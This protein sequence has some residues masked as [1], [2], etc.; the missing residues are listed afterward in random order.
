MALFGRMVIRPFT[1][2]FFPVVWVGF[3][4]WIGY[5]VA[6]GRTHWASPSG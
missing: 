3:G 2:L 6:T 5:Q 1:L 4:G